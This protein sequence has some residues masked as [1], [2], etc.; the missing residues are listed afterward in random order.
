MQH[1]ENK[2]TDIISA[3]AELFNKY[4][5]DAV[6]MNQIAK[7]VA[8]TKPALYY[9]FKNKHELFYHCID[10]TTDA[11]IKKTQL[12]ILKPT[13][14]IE[15]K[16][17]ELILVHIQFI[18]EHHEF[19]SYMHQKSQDDKKITELIHKKRNK[20]ASIT[21]ILSKEII[22]KKQ[23]HDII[24]P[25]D[26]T[27]AIMGLTKGMLCEQHPEKNTCSPKD[28]ALKITTIILS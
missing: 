11:F 23:I 26:I 27:H 22:E 2:K 8:I 28:T 21:E 16:L 19:M 7:K 14:S 24:T 17:Y 18:Q 10:Q 4:N 13:A 15:K 5:Y 9:H 25:K 12:I 3:A 1:T 20:V 6:S